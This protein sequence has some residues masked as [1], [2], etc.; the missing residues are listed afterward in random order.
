MIWEP[1]KL[2]VG[3]TL[4]FTMFKSDFFGEGIFVTQEAYGDQK[5]P[6]VGRRQEM[7]SVGQSCSHIWK[8][9]YCYF[10]K[11]YIKARIEIDF[12]EED[13]KWG[14]ESYL[15]G[16]NILYKKYKILKMTQTL[17]DHSYLTKQVLKLFLFV[18]RSRLNAFGGKT[19]FWLLLHPG[20]IPLI[21]EGKAQSLS[22]NEIV[23]VEKRC[24]FCFL[25]K[26]LNL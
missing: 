19:L 3:L 5:C 8:D 7:S 25:K 22:Y 13:M 20:P 15:L 11:S 18:T 24:S 6:Y 2:G 23:K 17:H 12:S 26:E 14:V 21:I 16:S 10:Q 1:V 9:N 4:L